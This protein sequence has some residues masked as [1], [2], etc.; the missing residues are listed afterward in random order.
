MGADMIIT[1]HH[2]MSSGHGFAANCKDDISPPSKIM[3]IAEEASLYLIEKRVAAKEKVKVNKEDIVT[4]LREMFKNH[5]Y[6]KVIDAFA[7]ANF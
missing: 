1:Q 2:G 7:K 6:Q 5:T 3:L 4:H